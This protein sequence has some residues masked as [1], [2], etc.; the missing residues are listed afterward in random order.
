MSPASVSWSEWRRELFSMANVTALAETG[1]AFFAHPED[2]D[3]EAGE[4]VTLSGRWH[5]F[6]AR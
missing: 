1:Y 6:P 2:G 4:A 3:E 5:S